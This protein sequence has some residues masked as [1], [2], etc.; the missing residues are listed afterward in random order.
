MKHTVNLRDFDQSILHSIGQFILDALLLE[1]QEGIERF[2]RDL[3]ITD[4]QW[5]KTRYV[6]IQNIKTEP[7]NRIIFLGYSYPT[8]EYLKYLVFDVRAEIVLE[9]GQPAKLILNKH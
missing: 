1:T 2:K 5:K 6:H 3:R 8:D 9:S 7:R 4:D